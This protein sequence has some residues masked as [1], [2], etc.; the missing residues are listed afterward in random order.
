[1]LLN[2]HIGNLPVPL[3]EPFR[4]LPEHGVFNTQLR[5]PQLRTSY[6]TGDTSWALSYGRSVTATWG[7]QQNHRRGP[8]GT[9]GV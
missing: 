7:T 9:N 4:D 6:G 5:T 2:F 8:L 3:P 1:M